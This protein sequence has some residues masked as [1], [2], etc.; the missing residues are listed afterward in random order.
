MVVELPPRSSCVMMV[1]RWLLWTLLEDEGF[2]LDEGFSCCWSF[3]CFPVRFQ[4]L[5]FSSSGE[6]F[7]SLLVEM[8]MVIHMMWPYIFV[9]SEMNIRNKRTASGEFH[10]VSMNHVEW[11]ISAW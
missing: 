8:H 11:D 10:I 2:L 4:G 9:M 5:C 1:V 3:C 6:D 7:H